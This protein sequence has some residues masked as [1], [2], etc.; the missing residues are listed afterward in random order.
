MK[1]SSQIL[2]GIKEILE[3]RGCTQAWVIKRMN[4][5]D[6]SLEMTPNKFSA[7]VHGSRKIAGDELL[8]FCMATDTNQDYFCKAIHPQKNLGMRG[9]E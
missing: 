8:A 1:I 2:T 6:P 7:I 3:T 4:D 5:I 9:D